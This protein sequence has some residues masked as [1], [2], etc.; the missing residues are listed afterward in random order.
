MSE[1]NVLSLVSRRKIKALDKNIQELTE[2]TTILKSTMQ[3]LSKYNH[4]SNV[5]NRVNDLFV[6]YKEVKDAKD[7][8][9][10]ILKRLKD[11]ETMEG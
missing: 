2:V 8:K 5:R 10:D 4:Y 6:F 9:L 3:I 7:K 1:N 11:E